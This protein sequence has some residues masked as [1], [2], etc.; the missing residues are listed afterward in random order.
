MLH[1]GKRE[2]NFYVWRFIMKFFFFC[3]VPAEIYLWDQGGLDSEG[4]E[5]GSTLPPGNHQGDE[6]ISWRVGVVVK[7]LSK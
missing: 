4:G 3:D 6:I 7:E 5:G 2:E 1:P